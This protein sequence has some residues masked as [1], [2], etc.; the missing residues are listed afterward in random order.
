MSGCATRPLIG[1]ASHTS[2]VKCSVSPK[3]S[4][5]GVPYLPPQSAH[6]HSR[7]RQGPATHP[8]STVH[9]IWAPAMDIL[10][11]IRSHVDSLRRPG[12]VSDLVGLAFTP[13]A[14]ARVEFS[15]DDSEVWPG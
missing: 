13:S 2:D 7:S 6:Q 8:S 4:R 10:R 5:N 9:A 12:V 15:V 3:P 14:A 1:P 11:V